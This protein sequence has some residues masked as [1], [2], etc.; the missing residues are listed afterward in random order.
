METEMIAMFKNTKE[1]MEYAAKNK[2][3]TVVPVD[4]Q[5]GQIVDAAK[6]AK[7]L[8]EALEN[9]QG[10]WYL[11]CLNEIGREDV[12][13]S[14]SHEAMKLL[15]RLQWRYRAEELREHAIACAR[16]GVER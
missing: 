13:K 15:K 4:I 12:N 6:D 10:D 14:S 7:E 2:V 1:A 11:Y 5:D 9:L 16:R 3:P 8:Y